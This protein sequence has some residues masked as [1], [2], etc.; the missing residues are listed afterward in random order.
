[1]FHW[2]KDLEQAS[3]TSGP[4]ARYKHLWS[5]FVLQ[6][7]KNPKLTLKTSKNKHNRYTWN[8]FC[9]GCGLCG[10]HFE[11]SQ[12]ESVDEQMHIV[13]WLWKLPLN[14]SIGPRD[15]LLTGYQSWLQRFMSKNKIKRSCEMCGAQNMCWKWSSATTTH[16]IKM[17]KW[18]HCSHFCAGVGSNC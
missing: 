7:C 10:S 15:I 14:V 18:V 9:V 3:S 11:L 13:W 4:Q 6:S 1:M 12:R 5:S 16:N 8:H 2:S 17:S